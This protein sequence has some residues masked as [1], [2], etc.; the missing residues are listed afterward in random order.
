MAT[1][2]PHQS[3][4]TAPSHWQ[5]GNPGDDALAHIPGE[6]GWP[7]VGNTFKMLADPHG[8]TRRMVEKYG[9][10]YKNKAFGGW[11]VALIGAEAN[12][13]LLM[14]RDKIFSSEQGWG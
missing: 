4:E 5:E 3:A 9:R 8:Q 7:I 10:V 14:N 1:L 11:N 12:E 13:M 6:G 2:A